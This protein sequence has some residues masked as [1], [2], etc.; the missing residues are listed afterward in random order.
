MTDSPFEGRPNLGPTI[1]RHLQAAGI[2]SVRV[3]ERLGAPAAYQRLCRHAGRRLPV[4]YYLYSLEGALRGHDW[5]QL[6][7]TDKAHLCAAAGVRTR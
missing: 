5:R 4:C 6:S 1:Q 7:K 3:L 2:G